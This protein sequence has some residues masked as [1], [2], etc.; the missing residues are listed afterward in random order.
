MLEP[1]GPAESTLTICTQGFLRADESGPRYPCGSA[2]PWIS[3]SPGCPLTR[4]LLWIEVA[5]RSSIGN[6]DSNIKST[7]SVLVL[8]EVRGR[9]HEYLPACSSSSYD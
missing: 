7:E 6:N 8:V 2:A 1:E 3:V 5:S 9:D 4:Y